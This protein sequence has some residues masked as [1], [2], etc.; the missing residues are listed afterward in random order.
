MKGKIVWVH[1]FWG[2]H[3]YTLHFTA[4]GSL[5]LPTAGHLIHV[6]TGADPGVSEKETSDVAG[7]SEQWR[8]L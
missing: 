1:L 2:I 7:V 6:F 5:S 4:S 8:K 3:K